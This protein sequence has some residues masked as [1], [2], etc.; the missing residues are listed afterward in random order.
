MSRRGIVLSTLFAVLLLAV[1]ARAH[2]Q[3]H[4]EAVWTQ[5]NRAYN[6]VNGEGFGSRNYIIGRMNS[7]T[8]DSWTLTLPGGS[9]YKLVGVCDNDCG[10]LDI[11]VTIGDDLVAEDVLDDDVPIVN[12]T[13]K[14]ENRYNIKV[15]MATCRSDPCFWGVAVFYK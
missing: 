9:S 3:S 8:S 6:Q 1:P 13:T 11:R 5:L 12:F 2:A 15:T 7:G 14:Q 4:A 10:D